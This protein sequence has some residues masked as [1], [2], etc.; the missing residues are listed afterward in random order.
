VHVSHIADQ[1]I[2]GETEFAIPGG[3]FISDGHCWVSMDQ[4]G[5]VK[6]GLDDFAKKLIG[7]IDDIEPPNLGM[8][9]QRGQPLFSVKQGERTITFHSPISG[10]VAKVNAALKKDVRALETT[11]YEKNWVCALDSDDLDVELPQLKIGKTAVTF[12]Q[13]EIDALIDLLHLKR[14]NGDHQRGPQAGSQLSMP[15]LKQLE[16]KDWTKLTNRFFAR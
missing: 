7:C 15:N 12:F 8:S 14:K 13:D 2:L 6:V 5:S 10:R 1:Q 16:R 11:P 3:V 4:D 9:I